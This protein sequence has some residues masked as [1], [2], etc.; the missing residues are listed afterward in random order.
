MA[1]GDSTA[2]FSV[3]STERVVAI[4]TLRQEGLSPFHRVQLLATSTLRGQRR[5]RVLGVNSK[6]IPHLFICKNC[7]CH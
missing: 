3:A 5:S 1:K 2:I 6:G 7:I 4:M